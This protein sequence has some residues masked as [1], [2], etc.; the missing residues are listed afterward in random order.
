MATR[1]PPSGGPSDPWPTQS[2]GPPSD[3]CY[4]PSP[5][6]RWHRVTFR[7]SSAARARPGRLGTYVA[8]VR[9]IV[10]SCGLLLRWLPL[11][12][13][14]LLVHVVL[15]GVVW[16]GMSKLVRTMRGHA[17]AR[18]TMLLVMHHP[19]RSPFGR[20]P[21]RPGRPSR[22]PARLR[23]PQRSTQRPPPRDHC[24]RD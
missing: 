18:Y 24:S 6:P 4:P 22:H 12:L 20:S 15:C 21:R 7:A 11:R 17:R 19:N 9:G 10:F 14:R 2:S 5:S 3:R 16:K 1:R 23:R 8:P 13:A